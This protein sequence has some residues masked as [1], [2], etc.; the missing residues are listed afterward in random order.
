M[1]LGVGVGVYQCASSFE[2]KTSMSVVTDAV[3]VFVPQLLGLCHSTLWVWMALEVD[4]PTDLRFS[5]VGPHGSQVL[6]SLS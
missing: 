2:R 5:T 3:I 6:R 1:V 4:A